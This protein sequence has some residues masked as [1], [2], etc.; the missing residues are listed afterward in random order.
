LFPSLDL[1]LK[2]ALDD[3]D[4][5]GPCV[6]STC[7]QVGWVL[8]GICNQDDSVVGREDL[9]DDATLAERWSNPSGCLDGWRGGSDS[10]FGC[11][12]SC[13]T[14]LNN[15]TS[16]SVSNNRAEASCKTAS[17]DAC[18]RAIGGLGRDEGQ[19]YCLER[20]AELQPSETHLG[21]VLVVRIFTQQPVEAALQFHLVVDRGLRAYENAVLNSVSVANGIF[22]LLLLLLLRVW[23]GGCLV[24]SKPKLREN[25]RRCRAEGI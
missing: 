18:K 12:R 13:P 9:G 1:D 16:T 10:R 19:T 4:D 24:I 11:R 5:I 7:V 6:E 20:I 14:S 15:A 17:Q 2:V 23:N 8:N 21:C 3:Q 22:R 25:C